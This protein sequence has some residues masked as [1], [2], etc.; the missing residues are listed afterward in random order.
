MYYYMYIILHGFGFMGD[1]LDTSP[2]VLTSSWPR[3]L[4]TKVLM[5]FREAE[6][7]SADVRR[8]RL[9]VKTI[10]KWENHRKTIGKWRFTL[11]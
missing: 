7:G 4:L 5:A 3:L 8:M 9:L 2:L 1:D 6:L 10:G 11:W